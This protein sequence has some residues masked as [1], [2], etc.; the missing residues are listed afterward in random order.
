MTID[1]KAVKVQVWDTSGRERF[2]TITRTY[3][4]KTPVVLI[5]YDVTDRETFKSAIMWHE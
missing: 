4:K 2:P 1:D 5:V 3:Y